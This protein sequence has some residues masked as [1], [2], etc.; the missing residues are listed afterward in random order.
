MDTADLL[1]PIKRKRLHEEVADRLEEMILDGQF[2]PGEALPS[3]TKMAARLNVSRAVVRAAA[4]AM[5]TKGLV[6]IRH[7]VG[8]FV[9]DS[10]RERTAE[11]LDL[12]VRRG[13]YTP[14]ELFVIRRGL[15]MIVVEQIIEHATA[16]QIAELKQSAARMKAAL[17][18][19]STSNL[20]SEHVHFHRL[21][22][23]YAGNRVLNDLIEPISVFRIPSH[24]GLPR[25]YAGD[26]DAFVRSHERIVDAIE[27]RDLAAAKREMLEHLE[28]LRVRAW[29]ATEQI[30]ES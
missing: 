2:A 28:P 14:W 21:L 11:A 23:Q 29:R 25:S 30:Q 4:G 26:H 20:K 27:R 12:S 10:G 13:D 8:V 5:A 24:M 15:E 17:G 7:G 1:K 9:T 18:S 16:G 3:E 22:V 19:A 6:E